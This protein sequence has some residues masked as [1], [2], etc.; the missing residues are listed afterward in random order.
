M[1][2]QPAD[3]EAQLRELIAE[4]H[5]ATKDLRNAIRDARQASASMQADLQA[6]VTDIVDGTNK[7]LTNIVARSHETWQRAGEQIDRK[8]ADLGEHIAG[9]M[10][11]N[12]RAEFATE[13]AKRLFIEV[14]ALLP[15]LVDK[16][17]SRHGKRRGQ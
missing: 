13:T 15:M 9:L 12:S 10:G 17:L 2:L 3:Q 1:G 7:E 5:G 11:A 8:A 6:A 14:E 4:A 16:A